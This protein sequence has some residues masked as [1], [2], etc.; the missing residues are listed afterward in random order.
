M[1]FKSRARVLS[2]AGAVGWVEPTGRANARPMTGFAIPITFVAAEAMGFAAL[3]PSYELIATASKRR[4][5]FTSA[6]LLSTIR[7]SVVPR[8]AVR[9]STAKMAEAAWLS[10]SGVSL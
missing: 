5:G 7:I 3:N 4:G 2:C 8:A 6:S 10:A 9:S 1:G